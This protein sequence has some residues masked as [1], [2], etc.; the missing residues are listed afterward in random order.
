MWFMFII[1]SVIGC[2]VADS[3]GFASTPITGF[4]T[5]KDTA[6]VAITVGLSIFGGLSPWHLRTFFRMASGQKCLPPPLQD[7]FCLY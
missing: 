1:V 6:A 4:A 5:P 7:L 2:P 3:V